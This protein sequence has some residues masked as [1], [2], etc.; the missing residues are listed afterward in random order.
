MRVPLGT[1]CPHS[2]KSCQAGREGEG[3][4][5]SGWAVEGTAQSAVES[6][7]INKEHN[8]AQLPHRL[9]PA[10]AASAPLSS[11]QQPLWPC[12]QRHTGKARDDGRDAHRLLDLRRRCKQ[13]EREALV[14][15]EHREQAGPTRVRLRGAERLPGLCLLDQRFGAHK[16][17][18]APCGPTGGRRR[19]G[20]A[21]IS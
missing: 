17:K 20:Q 6:A 8:S 12:L 9:S 10:P 14:E 7:A 18:L 13:Q 3:V 1:R 21:P 2:S 11:A 4:R 19:E 16:Q 15:G 5:S